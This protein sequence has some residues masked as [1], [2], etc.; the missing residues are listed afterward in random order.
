MTW[1]RGCILSPMARFLP[2]VCLLVTASLA[3][4]QAGDAK[5]RPGTVQHPPPAHLEIPPAPPLSP[6]EALAAFVVADGF[7]VELVAAEPL[8][9]DP[10]AATFAPDGTLWV[11]E[12]RG[13]MPDADGV[14]ELEPVGAIA[15]LHDD[16][17]DGRS[18]RRVEFLTDL[19]LP[20]AVLPTRGGA[21]V[22]TPPEL[23]FWRDTDGDG[24]AD[25]R[26]VVDTGLGGLDNPE[27]AVNGLLP[28]LDNA[29]ACA[30]HARRYRWSDVE[31]R[32]V[33]EQTSGGG[34]WGITQD[35]WGDLFFN[36]NSAALRTDAVPSRYGARNPN[37]GDVPG[38][39]EGCVDDTRVWPAR[40]TTGVN[41]G[42]HQGL[43]D[44]Q[45]RLTRLTAAC[46]PS[47]D[48]SAGLPAPYAGGAFVAE[49][50]ANA[51]KHYALDDAD[52][53]GH[54]RGRIAVEGREFLASLDER[55]R[56]VQLFGGPDAGVYVVD[57]ARG[58]IQHR[59][60]MTTFLRRQ[61]DERGL[62]S[63]IGLGRIWRVKP[64]GTT[65]TAPPDM[66]RADDAELV[67][68]LGHD[69][70]WWRDAAQRVLVERPIVGRDATARMRAIVADDDAA[71]L[72]RVHALWTLAGRGLLDADAV[73]DLLDP[74]AGDA[75]LEQVLR[76]SETLVAGM[77]SPR[78]LAPKPRLA[79]ALRALAT[80]E[81]TS[82]RVRRQVAFTA[83]VARDDWALPLLATLLGERDG[84]STSAMRSA[85]LSGLRDR[86]LLFAQRLVAS[87]AWR[88]AEP[89][90]DTLLRLLARASVRAGRSDDVDALLAL[91]VDARPWQQLALLDGL[92]DAREK[93]GDVLQPIPV[94]ARPTALDDLA[95]V[96]DEAVF[97][98][99]LGVAGALNW[100]GRPP[101]PGAPPPPRPLTDDERASFARGRDVYA[102][103]CAACHQAS[104]RGEPGLA[105]PLRGSSW[106]L[107]APDVIVRV[108]RDG[109][110]GPIDVD[111]K[112]WNMLMPSLAL[113]DEDVADVVTYVRRE[114]GHGAEPVT[115]DDV[116]RIAAAAPAR[117]GAWTAEELDDVAG[118]G[119]R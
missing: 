93:H 69:N 75:W 91:T 119:T 18:D 45:G 48:R 56:P 116:A 108:V 70:G 63:P 118:R 10:V 103:T 3:H 12:M 58:I 59:I 83:G 6:D 30:N 101:R 77:A 89:G 27:H 107:G 65:F 98:K 52:G 73:A 31:E 25:E 64:R 68:W 66:T 1:P 24:R 86:E 88:D 53:D 42:Y 95:A 94:A 54:V 23:V 33:I 110:E 7:D 49:P 78:P 85:A 76:A 106:V 74:S 117:D 109:L 43:L 11:V 57:M 60:Y 26:T 61:V 21:L 99:M 38:T 62:A 105:P 34:Q 84:A 29:I 50:A 72:H 8:V 4:G 5:D 104:G 71:V 79:V 14:G 97:E 17:G 115:P 47:I 46:G 19:V 16:D 81:H 113:G 90:R 28:T 13:Y 22:I 41:R 35:D 9:G 51:V 102:A 2:L 15:V 44:E 67:A 92:L 39:N 20:R 55:F 112:A 100:P 32:F 114:W 40:I 37:H 80:D 82:P 87:P 36:T 96:T 111:G